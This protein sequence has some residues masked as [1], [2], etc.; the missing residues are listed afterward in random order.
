MYHA[1]TFNF[2][3]FLFGIHRKSDEGSNKKYIV[4]SS[5]I[6]LLSNT[7][8]LHGLLKSPNMRRYYQLLVC[9]VLTRKVNKKKQQKFK[10]LML[11]LAQIVGS[12]RDKIAQKVIKA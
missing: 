11:K 3:K 12:E 4:L 5:V 7:V 2:C 8:I 1:I 10:F 6:Y 9:C